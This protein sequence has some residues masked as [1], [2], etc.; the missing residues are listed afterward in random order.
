MSNNIAQRVKSEIA[1]HYPVMLEEVL[2]I[3]APKDGERYLDCTFGGGSHSK[4]ILESANCRLDALDRDPNARNIAQIFAKK[5]GERFGFFNTNFSNLN[6]TGFSQ[7]AGII[8]DLGVSSF[9]IDNAERGFSFMRDGPTDMRMNPECGQ[10]ALEL[11]NTVSQ[12]ELE[13]ILKVYGEEP[14][15]RKVAQAII[16]ARNTDVLKRT[17]SLAELIAKNAAFEKGKKTNP[18]TR[19]FQAIRIAVNGELSEIENALPKAFDALKSGG[20]LAVISFHSLEDRIV[21]R[22]FKSLAGM[23]IDAND[24]TCQQDR[25]KKAELLTRKA[26]VAS[27]VE[28][29]ENPRSRSAKLRAVRKL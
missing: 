5:Y 3:I 24:N 23:P 29:L 6:E 25:V 18:A 11:L 21:K 16:D 2:A 1:G 10:S 27:D 20:V 28:N 26:I 22:F 14:R 12:R 7:Y 9:Q 17:K 15:Y 8:M 4:A 13:R 19:S